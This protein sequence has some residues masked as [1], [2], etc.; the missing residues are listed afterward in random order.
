[1]TKQQFK[2]LLRVMDGEFRVI[3]FKD[4]WAYQLIVHGNAYESYR[5]ETRTKAY[6]DG[7]KT[8]QELISV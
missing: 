5:F 8:F 7:K 2:G 4:G 1:M 6:L 3:R